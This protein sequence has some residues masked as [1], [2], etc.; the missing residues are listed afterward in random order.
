MALLAVT[1]PLAGYL[2]LDRLFLRSWR[3]KER[4][5]ALAKLRQENKD[6]LAARKLEAL[7]ATLLLSQTLAKRLE[8]ETKTE[9]G[10]GLVILE[11]LYGKLPPSSLEKARL[12]S[13]AGIQDLVT[14]F[15][16]NFEAF[17]SK[18]QQEGANEKE[19]EWI[20]VTIPVQ[21]LVSSGQLHI[22]A[23]HSKSQLLG[24]YDPCFGEEKMLRVVYQ[25]RGKLH[26]VTV[27]D[28]FALDAPLRGIVFF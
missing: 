7:S 11:A 20:D 22:P 24:F 3:L 17:L 2:A 4:K 16:A 13:P 9:G 27:G 25:V 1:V 26:V 12:L 19:E 6:M 8:A 5:E 15:Q 18:G 10:G 21:A 14:Q 23:S 28:R